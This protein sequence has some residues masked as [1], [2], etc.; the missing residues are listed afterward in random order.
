MTAKILILGSTGML[1]HRVYYH[2][3]S[4][5]EFEVFDVSYRSKL[6]P[7]T[8]LINVVD[9]NSLEAC[10]ARVRPDVIVN[11]VGVLIRGSEDVRNAI[12]LN[13]L[14]PHQLK[15]LSEVYGAKLIHISTDCVFSGATGSYTEADYKDGEGAYAET[16]SLGEIIDDRNLT[17]RTSII[18]P[19]LKG[20]G[21]GLFHWFM[22]QSG[23]V[24]GYTQS[25]WSG[26]TTLELAK[27]IATAIQGNIT[28]LCHVTNNIPISKYELLK[29]FQRHTNK[30][31][32]IEP[33]DGKKIDKSFI[34]TRK[35]LSYEVPSYDS[36]I[37]DMAL[38]ISSHR[39]LYSQ[40]FS[41]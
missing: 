27:V 22:M 37:R 21:E 14:L 11:C 24:S 32:K 38:L 31:I 30:N 1:G 3:Q 9:L 29:L 18:G 34:D 41:D 39:A 19:E 17:L 33:V 4:F 28:G 7:A 12:Q 16:K 23:T 35:I 36:M 15:G 2:L 40:Y 8:E 6:N 13:A 25:V 26:V 20:D 10:I 5:D